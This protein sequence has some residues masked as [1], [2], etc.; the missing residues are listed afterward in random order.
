MQTRTWGRTGIQTGEIGIGCEGFLG[1]SPEQVM[2]MVDIMEAA[3]VNCIDLYTPNP[4]FRDSLGLALRGRR[5]KFVLQAHL[6]TIWRD[7]QYKRTRDLALISQLAEADTA[8]AVVA[9][10]CVRTA[11]NLAAVIMPGREL[12]SLL[13]LEYHCLLRHVNPPPY[14]AN[15]APS[16]LSNSRASSSA[17]AVVQITTSMPRTLSI[18]SYEIS[19]KIS[20]SFRPS[21]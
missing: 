4:E 15:G 17:F 2:E 9:Q 8:N 18:W 12:R 3:G 10:V 13:L 5:E 7:G 11:A 19:G 21:A 14:F 6:C 16:R 1:K 20:C